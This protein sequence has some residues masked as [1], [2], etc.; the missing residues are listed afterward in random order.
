MTRFDNSTDHV[1]SLWLCQESNEAADKHQ[2]LECDHHINM[3]SSSDAHSS[4]P[5]KKEIL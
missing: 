5:L 2:L 4:D 3:S 1:P